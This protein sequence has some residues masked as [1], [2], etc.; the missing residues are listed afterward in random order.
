MYQLASQQLEGPAGP[1]PRRGKDWVAQLHVK[2]FDPQVAE[3]A[4]GYLRHLAGHLG[5][6]TGNVVRLPKNR[7]LLTVLRSPHVNK[8]ARE[9]FAKDTYKRLICIY[10]T[11]P[12][13]LDVFYRQVEQRP[14]VGVLVKITDRRGSPLPAPQQ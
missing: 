10:D 3:Y 9:Q 1:P 6:R 11:A 14:P 13:A 2:A 7:K 8:T 12:E 5:V 4:C